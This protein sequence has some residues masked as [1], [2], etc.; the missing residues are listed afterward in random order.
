LAW[1]KEKGID[2]VSLA[3]NHAGDAGRAGLTEALKALEGAGI[4]VVGAGRND[5]EA[6][7]PWRKG[8]AFAVFGVCLVE[9]LTATVD[10]A[11]V[12]K[13]PEHALMLEAELLKAR[14]AGE[15]IIVMV[16]GGDEYQRAVN[17]EQRTWAR[18]LAR[19]GA[20]LI[21]GSH[22]HVIQRTERHAGAVIAHS[23]GNAVYP[24]SLG[25]AH[26]G[27]VMIFIPPARPL[28]KR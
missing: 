7:R 5:A 4:A 22:P 11:G 12:A 26:S 8:T 20:D 19:R 27:E 17:E 23:L 21:V 16:H 6:C 1:L 9:S 15:T 10:Q 14:A 3:N 13:L 25:N 18:W 2:A 24:K 28:C